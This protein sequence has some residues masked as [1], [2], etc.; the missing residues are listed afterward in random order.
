MSPSNLETS[1]LQRLA[2]FLLDHFLNFFDYFLSFSLFVLFFKTV[3]NE[4]L[5]PK[6]STFKFVSVFSFS[7]VLLSTQFLHFIGGFVLYQLG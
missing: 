1:S 7:F 3:N 6:S 5:G 2:L 4:A